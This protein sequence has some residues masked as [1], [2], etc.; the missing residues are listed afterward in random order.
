MFRK[1]RSVDE[2]TDRLVLSLVIRLGR[3]GCSPN[4]RAI[5]VIIRTPTVTRVWGSI[6]LYLQL[7]KGMALRL[8]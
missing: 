5:N 8:R 1:L 2:S 7:M 6:I 4:Y 3:V